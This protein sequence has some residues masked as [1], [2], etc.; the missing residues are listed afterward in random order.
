MLQFRDK[1]EK[2]LTTP[3]LMKG[4]QGVDARAMPPRR[5]PFRAVEGA[6]PADVRSRA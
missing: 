5:A 3:R 6:T 1:A 2:F 4:P